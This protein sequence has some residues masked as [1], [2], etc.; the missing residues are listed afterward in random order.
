MQDLM[1]KYTTEYL[2]KF[3]VVLAHAFDMFKSKQNGAVL[4]PFKEIRFYNEAKEYALSLHR[5]GMLESMYER[6]IK[7]CV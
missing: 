7:K 3:D 2:S 6:I 1:E 4:P 5:M